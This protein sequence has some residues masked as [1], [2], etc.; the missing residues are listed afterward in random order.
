M[1]THPPVPIKRPRNKRRSRVRTARLRCRPRSRTGLSAPQA[2]P[3]DQSAEAERGQD[4]SDDNEKQGNFVP[5][6]EFHLRRK[7]LLGGA[8][9]PVMAV[10]LRSGRT[11]N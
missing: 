10:Q 1:S 7:A 9:R 2:K 6:D 4:T 11:F 3:K 8:S 5:G